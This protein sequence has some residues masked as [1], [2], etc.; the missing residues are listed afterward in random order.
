MSILIFSNCR[1]KEK[2]KLRL[3]GEASWATWRRKEQATRR[4]ETATRRKETATR[5][6][7]TAS[8]R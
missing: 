5:L 7:L 8:I 1:D 4:K 3:L 2:E 6:A